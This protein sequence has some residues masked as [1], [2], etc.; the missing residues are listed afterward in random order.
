MYYTFTDEIT[1]C[2]VPLLQKFL[3]EALLCVLRDKGPDE[4]LHVLENDCEQ[5]EL[6]WNSSL[7]NELLLS[8]TEQLDCLFSDCSPESLE[9]FALDSMFSIKFN[10]L[11]N[12]LY[13]GGVYVRLFMK[14]PSYPLKD[15]VGFFERLMAFWAQLMQSIVETNETIENQKNDD[16]M[17]EITGA[18]SH[19]CGHSYLCV[20]L[21]PWGYMK[22]AIVFIHNLTTK[23]S[24]QYFLLSAITL[25]HAAS[26]AR[27]NVEGILDTCDA[28]GK[29]G[30]VDGIMKSIGTSKLHPNTSFM[31]ETLKNIALNTLGDV[32]LQLPTTSLEST[33]NWQQR[34]VVGIDPSPAPGTEPVKN[35]EKL[36][37][38][39]P[40][41]MLLGNEGPTQTKHGV[42]TV[43]NR[44]TTARKSVHNI[45]RKNAST[46]QPPFQ[47]NPKRSHMDTTSVSS[48]SERDKSTSY[49]VNHNRPGMLLQ[50]GDTGPQNINNTTHQSTKTNM[51]TGNRSNAHSHYKHPLPVGRG[52]KPLRND[53]G[54]HKLSIPASTVNNNNVNS[55]STVRPHER[56]QQVPSLHV[57]NS[58]TQYSTQL[59]GPTK[60]R[61]QHLITNTNNIRSPNLITQ[62]HNSVVQHHNNF[63]QNHHIVGQH[64]NNFAQNHNNNSLNQGLP[65]VGHNTVHFDS[66]HHGTNVQY[67]QANSQAVQNQ[68]QLHLATHQLQN[69]HQQQIAHGPTQPNLYQHQPLYQSHAS[70]IDAVHQANRINHTDSVIAKPVVDPKKVAKEKMKSIDGAPN[71]AKGRKIFLDSVLSCGLIP[72]L[73]DNILEHPSRQDILD[74]DATKL[75][76][77]EI[78]DLLSKD[79]GYGLMFHIILD[80]L[81]NWSK[82]KK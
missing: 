71:C 79:P 49:L 10:G 64:H 22:R 26:H 1:F 4:M 40:L 25:L 24:Y 66:R 81:P 8:I 3:P 55:I 11:E 19:L 31:L 46:T 38:G 33:E 61:A 2:T 44:N 80:A 69:H 13:I 57:V 72:F 41:S 47:M 27:V 21:A 51:N 58:N 7:K 45:N 63:A 48:R 32:S 68:E 34:S 5:P 37:G 36:A 77:I 14:N 17:K 70:H 43:R 39:D 18:F 74:E 62:H 65:P 53:G 50:H 76:V 52:V 16:K 67:N 30:I 73:V 42:N 28:D 75:H 56:N 78:I 29:H 23:T 54:N 82:Y 35:M 59:M 12:E 20:K 15:P 6:V 9:P 60:T